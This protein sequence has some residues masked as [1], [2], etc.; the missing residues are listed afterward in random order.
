MGCSLTTCNESELVLTQKLSS[1]A[2]TQLPGELTDKSTNPSVASGG[3]LDSISP[4]FGTFDRVKAAAKVFMKKLPNSSAL[5]KTLEL[6]EVT[7]LTQLENFVLSPNDLHHKL[8]INSIGNE[9][10]IIHEVDGLR[11]Y[12]SVR[13]FCK[14][15]SKGS[16]DE[17][18]YEEI[19][20][21][22]RSLSPITISFML[23]LG[24]TVDCMIG[25]N[26]PL[27]RRQLTMF[28]KPIAESNAIGKWSYA[29]NQPIPT[30]VCFS[31]LRNM[32]S[33]HFYSFDGMK[34]QNF[35]RCF[36]IFEAFAAPLSDSIKEVLYNSKN[37]EMH[38][39]LEFLDDNLSGMGVLLQSLEGTPSLG[40]LLDTPFNEESWV[41]FRQVIGKGYLK[42][43]LRSEGY[44][45]TQTCSV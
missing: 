41:L 45:M 32:K 15:Y 8:S 21:F 39:V 22:L 28:L 6:W 5:W 10:T 16:F 37:E 2:E 7:V 36:S 43:M 33:L 23:V 13:D 40:R 18:N 17:D 20:T 25:V 38:C 12:E 44:T 14:I 31:C 26:K 24:A 9:F 34:K 27:D 35:D 42:L 1:L 19:E 4:A 30:Q 29:Q 3:R 11:S